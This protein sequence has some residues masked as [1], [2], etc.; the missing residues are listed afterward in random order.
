M[1]RCAGPAGEWLVLAT[2]AAIPKPFPLAAAPTVPVASDFVLDSGR[3]ADLDRGRSFYDEAGLVT[4]S[5]PRS[6]RWMGHRQPRGRRR[7]NCLTETGWGRS[8]RE[9]DNAAPVVERGSAGR[10]AEV[11]GG[12]EQ[13]RVDPDQVTVADAVEVRPAAAP[14]LPRSP[15]LRRH[16]AAERREPGGVGRVRGGPVVHELVGAVA[17]RESAPPGGIPAGPSSCGGLLPLLARSHSTLVPRML[18]K[19]SPPARPATPRGTTRPVLPSSSGR[20]V[21]P[22]GQGLPVEYGHSC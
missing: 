11:G 9:H 21:R 19:C 6:L 5:L 4:G 14:P 12:T 13:H 16:D 1:V 10:V 2:M 17:V 7:K 18:P 15:P 20:Y 8:S 22:R 3:V